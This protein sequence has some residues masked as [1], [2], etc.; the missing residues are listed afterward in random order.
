MFR[1]IVLIKIIIILLNVL[2]LNIYA[3]EDEK[4]G[5]IKGVVVDKDTKAPLIGTNIM[6]LGSV[7]GTASD[8]EGQYILRKLPVG[9][10][11]LEFKFIGYE[12]VIKTD[13]IVKSERI[14]SVNV[15][16]GMMII[17]SD[18]VVVTGGF[19]Q[20]SD[21]ELTSA[22]SFSYEEIRRAP[23]SAGDVSRIIMGLPSVAKV[24]DQ[25]NSLIVR[26][27]SPNENG[28]IIDNIEIPNINHFPTQGSSGGPI[29]LLN[30]D[31][32]Q[33][34]N[35]YSGGFSALYGDKL[36]S[37]MEIE[38]REGNREE[39]DGQLDLNFAGFGGVAEGPL[40]GSKGSW[41]IS[42]RRSYIDFLI[43]MVD[44]G[45]TIAPIYG[46]VQWKFVY[47]LHPNH[48]LTFLGIIGDD[49]LHSDQE[50]GIENDMVLY[51]RQDVV[52]GTVGINWRALW[53]SVGYSN[54][55]IALT[56]NDFDEDAYRT[57]TGALFF[58]NNTLEKS[59]NF[60]NVNHLKLSKTYSLEFGFDGKWILDKYNNYFAPGIDNL[61]SQTEGVTYK[62]NFNET[63]LGGF[64]NW[65]HNPVEGVKINT[66]LRAD[67]FSFSEQIN[68]SP[69][70]AFSID[71]SEHTSLN[72]SFGIFTQTLP[73]LLLMQNAQLEKLAHPMATHYIVGL[74][75]LFAADTKLTIEAYSKKY[76]NFPLDPS[77]PT[78][79]VIDEI[80]D[81]EGLYLSHD[82]LVDS[83]EAEA[84]GI[85]V[86]LQKK[87]AK[88][89]YG[90]ISGSYFRTRYRDYNS[91]WHNRVFDNKY[92]AN[93]EGGYK[94]NDE[95]EFSIRWI[96][97]G[98]RPYTPFDQMASQDAGQGIIDVTDINNKRYPAYHSMNLRVD[99][100]FHF[101]STNLVV[102]LSVWNVYNRKNTA[103]I[104]WDE[105]NNRE[106]NIF[107]WSL[108]PIFG[109]EYEF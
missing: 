99:K 7:Q 29:G 31:F 80:Y 19:F 107:Q 71:L 17:S 85:E 4:V 78:S 77:K 55:S 6:I 75:H 79:F 94:P 35:F 56:I 95:W 49:H 22:T 11:T 83:G 91:D 3:D 44:V 57:S 10:Y 51:A 92:V 15:E 66:G 76:R 74:S 38:L 89:F 84:W 13:V 12:S 93:I 33:D 103:T 27:G 90:M 42:A 109:I 86:M 39:F 8:I 81:Q 97:A 23:G 63:K 96:Y 54:T 41:L 5:T 36:S 52:E 43:D 105:I 82:N 14:T 100:R 61:G 25:R 9:N 59:F 73:A 2:V 98:G 48:K 102:Y 20:S 62:N 68:F 47:D 46:D 37:I 30:V 21:D 108:L 70:F 60:R 69:R 45:S 53:G 88:D 40:F 50:N 18:E 1:S 87:L 65:T 28:F 34:V 16:L 58:Q 101:S 64:V 106:K 24:D 67:Y 72:A 104:F 26:G 32:I